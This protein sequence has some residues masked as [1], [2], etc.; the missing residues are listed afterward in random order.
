MSTFNEVQE[1]LNLRVLQKCPPDGGLQQAQGAKP[2]QAL[3]SPS[4]STLGGSSGLE[5]LPVNCG[6]QLESEPRGDPLP[7]SSRLWR[8]SH[9]FFPP[10]AFRRCLH[11]LPGERDAVINSHLTDKETEAQRQKELS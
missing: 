1:A 2:S 10:W 11:K 8:V 5:S 3:V 6:K 9:Q 4:N 7:T